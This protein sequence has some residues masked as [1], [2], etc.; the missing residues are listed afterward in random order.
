MEGLVNDDQD[1]MMFENMILMLMKWMVVAES[2]RMDRM[3]EMKMRWM[4]RMGHDLCAIMN[5]VSCDNICSESTC[6]AANYA[7][8]ANS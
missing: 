8:C 3:T 7:P 6:I 2:S 1:A 4:L 5:G